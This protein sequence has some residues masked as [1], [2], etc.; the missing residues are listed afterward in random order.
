MP[1]FFHRLPDV[2]SNEAKSY[3]QSSTTRACVAFIRA[4]RHW[5]FWLGDSYLAAKVL[6]CYQ[7]LTIIYVASGCQVTETRCK[8][9]SGPSVRSCSLGSGI[10]AVRSSVRGRNTSWF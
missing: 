5:T 1:M 4:W 9:G 10:V 6:N 8:P 7:E 3:P 2:V